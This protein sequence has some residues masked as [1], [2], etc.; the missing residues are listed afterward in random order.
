M[1]NSAPQANNS[2]VRPLKPSNKMPMMIGA[3]VGI[4][5]IGLAVGW[6]ISSKR[7]SPKTLSTS[8]SNNMVNSPTEAGVKDPSII[9]NVT[10]ATGTLQEGGIQGEGTFHLDRPGGKT[11]TVSLT[12]TSIDMSPFVGK[13]TQVW[14]LTQ[15][16]Q[17]S[18]WFMD[19]VKIKVVE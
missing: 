2:G 19:V 1:E 5:F 14:G 18:P 16:S 8:T 4:I 6:F 17:H 9:K 10:T 7:I 12:S 3:L 13:K 15:A 11:Q